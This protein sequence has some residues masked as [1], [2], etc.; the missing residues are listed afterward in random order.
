MV[1]VTINRHPGGGRDPGNGQRIWSVQTVPSPK[2]PS[3]SLTLVWVP[4]SVGMTVDATNSEPAH[5]LSSRRTPGL[6]A[7]FNNPT[8]LIG[9]ALSQGTASLFSTEPRKMETVSFTHWPPD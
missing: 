3:G 7:H 1:G 2:H 6:T 9:H 4:T 5:Q 8:Y